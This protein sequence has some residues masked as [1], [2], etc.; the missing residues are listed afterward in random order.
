MRTANWSACEREVIV[1]EC[2]KHVN[3]IT[4]AVSS[5]LTMATNGRLWENITEKVNSV[6]GM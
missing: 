1:S 6:E 5:S 3:V 4:T 2:T